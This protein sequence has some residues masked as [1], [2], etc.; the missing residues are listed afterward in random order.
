[1]RLS[2]YKQAYYE[3]SGKAS[4]VARQLAFAGIIIVWIFKVE[5][6]SGPALPK[7]LL[8]PTILLCF[9]LACDLLHYI[10]G[11][12][13]WGVF[14]RVHEKR[15]PDLSKDP[16]L[17]ASRSLNWPLNVLFYLKLTGVILAYIMLLKF[18]WNV[19]P[20]A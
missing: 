7:G 16:E 18:F 5:G 3:F 4:D 17:A 15:N 1:M 9:S 19:W 2:E 14:H 12:I 11:T 6:S 13:T 20:L 8:F 10:V